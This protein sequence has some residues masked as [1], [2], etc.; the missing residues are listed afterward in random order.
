MTTSA[1]H[2]AVARQLNDSGELPEGWT[3]STIGAAFEIN[4]RKVPKDELPEAAPV[5]FVPMPAVD[6]KSRTITTPQ[7][8]PF[9]SVRKGYTSFRENDVLFAKITP[10]MEN[11]K[12]AIARD[13]TNGLGFGSTEFHVIRPT[14]AAVPEYVYYLIGQK[15]FRIAA[16]SEMTGSVGQKRVPPS[17]IENT[18]LPIPPLAEQ[19]R[20]VAQVEALLVRVNAARERLAKVAAIL[21]RFRQSVL[22]AACS[23]QLTTDWREANQL[24]ESGEEVIQAIKQQRIK[25]NEKAISESKKRGIQKPRR[26]EF[27]NSDEVAGR[28]EIPNLWGACALSRIFSVETGATPLRK[29]EKEFYENGTIPWVKTGEVKNCDILKAEEGITEQ[30]LAETNTKIF[31]IN[32]ILIA[33]YGEGKTRGQVGRLKIK[34]ATNQACAALVNSSLPEALNKYV[35]LFCL[36]QYKKIREQAVGGNQPNLNLDKIKR[37]VINIPPFAEQQEIVRRVEPLFALAD[38]IEQRVQAATERVEKATQSILARAFRG[39]LVET[40]AELAR[41]EGRDYESAAQL[42]EH[43]RSDIEKK[44]RP[45]PR[46][47]AARST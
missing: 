22:V 10:C 15:S 27:T 23:G 37:W 9:S 42:L 38:R 33:M 24:A 5:T 26:I 16:E 8:K 40:E 29:R 25:A 28:N 43:I 21:K 44:S 30:A 12:A 7:E 17:F 47:G 31:P 3:L 13:L 41:R 32:T 45:K 34:A 14:G 35:F 18:S 2:Q 46:A 19:K 1:V 39:E 4:P 6:A 36:S 11:G 20:I